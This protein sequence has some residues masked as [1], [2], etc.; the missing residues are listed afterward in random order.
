M[1][2][3][4]EQTKFENVHSSFFHSANRNFDVHNVNDIIRLVGS[5]IKHRKSHFVGYLA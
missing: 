1:K 4:N 3:E 5:N 2:F